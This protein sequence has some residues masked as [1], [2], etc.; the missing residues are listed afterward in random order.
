MKFLKRIKEYFS[1]GFGPAWAG[2]KLILLPIIALAVIVILLAVLLL[3]GRK[4][5]FR[6]GS[7]SY[8]GHSGVYERSQDDVSDSGSTGS[9]GSETDEQYYMRISEQLKIAVPCNIA[10]EGYTETDAESIR[11]DRVYKIVYAGDDTALRVAPDVK[12]SRYILTSDGCNTVAPTDLTVYHEKRADTNSQEFL[13]IPASEGGYYIVSKSSGKML[14]NVE[15][16][17]MLRDAVLSE[18]GRR[19]SIER[20]EEGR[21]SISSVAGGVLNMV[22]GGMVLESEEL[23]EDGAWFIYE[24]GYASWQSVFVDNFNP[25]FISAM[26]K[27]DGSA[28]TTD[29]GWVFDGGRIEI[30]AKAAG[31]AR[32]YLTTLTAA[33][34]EARID[35]FDASPATGT[36]SCGVSFADGR[37]TVKHGTLGVPDLKEWHE[38]AVEWD[39]EQIRFYFDGVMYSVFNI[40]TDAARSSFSGTL[41]TLRIEGF[42]VPYSDGID[43]VKFRKRKGETITASA[44][45]SALSPSASASAGGECHAAAAVNCG[46]AVA[47]GDKVEFYDTAGNRFDSI[48][49]FGGTPAELIPSRDGSRFI[50]IC[51]G[52]RN[53]YIVDSATG[54][55]TAL[56]GHTD[57]VTCAAISETGLCVTGSR[58]GTVRIWNSSGACTATVDVDGSPRSIAITGFADLFAVGCNDGRV[59]VFNTSTRKLSTFFSGHTDAVTVTRFITDDKLATGDAGGKLMFWSIPNDVR[60][61]HSEHCLSAISDI[62]VCGGSVVAA[63]ADGALRVYRSASPAQL[64]A[65][66]A[67]H[68]AAICGI[69]CGSSVLSVGYDGRAF[70]CDP[71]LNVKRELKGMTGFAAGC[72]LSADG[73]HALICSKSGGVFIYTL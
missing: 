5:P 73:K 41:M 68:N 7:A 18:A 9:D 71:A 39:P 70:L 34:E 64:T 48:G 42:S 72:A 50:V 25:G 65:E 59:R 15:G 32:A 45:G 61:Y 4:S 22:R 24:V 23:L 11:S 10:Q 20:G 60:Y 47:A 54:I 69:S 30:K 40:T 31:N 21:Y 46:F 17:P 33:G 58:D 3:F 55:S 51:R 62:S 56:S 1:Q 2:S 38:Y 44:G 52:S 43:Y 16:D 27:K 28:L 63:G 66:R 35:M 37:K 26:W 29:G 57:S 12:D 19:W 6:F 8:G 14:S 36:L 67:L 49:G 13:L 53:A